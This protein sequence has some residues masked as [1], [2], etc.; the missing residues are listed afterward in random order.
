MS[1]SSWTRLWTKI[2][3]GGAR[4]CAG[5]AS[6][7]DPRRAALISLLVKFTQG[8][9]GEM[10]RNQLKRRRDV[11]SEHYRRVGVEEG[12]H[13]VFALLFRIGRCLRRSQ[14]PP[15]SNNLG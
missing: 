8:E 4:N 1:S 3:S 15:H 2:C 11:W 9:F 6:A 10:V 12:P 5:I 13:L 14:V 7:A